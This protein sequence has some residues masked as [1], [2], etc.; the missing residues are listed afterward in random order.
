MNFHEIFRNKTGHSVCTHFDDT[1]DAT[2][3][4]KQPGLFQLEDI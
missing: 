3:S 2:N 1:N 4:K